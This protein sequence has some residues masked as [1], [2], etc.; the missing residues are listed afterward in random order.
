VSEALDNPYPGARPL[1]DEQSHLLF[2]REELLWKFL[3]AV[4]HSN[5]VEL[6]GTSGVGKSSLIRAGLAGKVS[7]RTGLLVKTFSDWSRVRA[8]TG[9]GR[10]AQAVSLAL[11][12]DAVGLPDPHSDAVAFITAAQDR[13]GGDL[14]IVFDQLEELLRDEPG[15]GRAFLADIATVA[16]TFPNGY[17]QV[18]SAR[19]EYKYEF[20]I[21]EE[22]L[23]E[24]LWTYV[25]IPPVPVSAVSAVISGPLTSSRTTISDDVIDAVTGGW[26]GTQADFNDASISNGTP[27]GGREST[28]LLHLQAFLFSL[29]E[30]VQP[31][32]GSTIT[33]ADVE[34]LP[35]IDVSLLATE[36]DAFFEQALNSYVTMTMERCRRDYVEDAAHG[37]ARDRVATETLRVAAML[38]VHLSSSGYKLVRGTDELA[39][40]VLAQD[41]R[42]LQ[43]FKPGNDDMK[44][45]A[46]AAVMERI[47]REKQLEELPEVLSNL[48]EDIPALS[49]P[50]GTWGDDWATAGRMVGNSALRTA[51]EIVASYERA[52]T[53]LESADLIRLTNAGERSERRLSLVHDGIGRALITWADGVM[54]EPRVAIAT[55]NAITGRQVLYRATDE[56]KTLGPEDLPDLKRLAWLGCNITAHF[57]G[58]WFRDCNFAGS[59]FKYS[60]FTDVVFENCNLGSVLFDATTF[61]D[62]TLVD[63]FLGGTL[64][65][66]TSIGGGGG[67]LV[68]QTTTPGLDEP[69][70]P[71]LTVGAGCAI[72]GGGL[73]FQDVHGYG[74]VIEGATGG[75]WTIDSGV[76]EHLRIVGGGTGLT[77]G[78][79]INDPVIRLWSATN[80]GHPS[81]FPA[82][83]GVLMSTA[84]AT[85]E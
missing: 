19:L 46:L 33:M 52:I 47:C 24:R 72:S 28:G 5:V 71:L 53:W 69:L 13:W 73:T 18:V 11:G 63:C 83:E 50:D 7:S 48:A 9:V 78:R 70:S 36:P 38:P 10:Y 68:R 74:L 35:G 42:E 44:A 29:F 51:A 45:E 6:M 39:G 62:V 17:T 22:N 55:V 4:R 67:L 2:G 82:D 15:M 64:V 20:A 76:L 60:T 30:Q 25:E 40:L 14:V 31:A 56:E 61:V 1:G 84:D 32:P 12:A 66:R 57:K 34:S 43:N 65:R 16:R 8:D 49:R 27:H 58:V 85:P 23:S 59:L 3:D 26:G 80:V 77:G 81:P 54:D 41:L 37:D 75:P 79:L 21:I